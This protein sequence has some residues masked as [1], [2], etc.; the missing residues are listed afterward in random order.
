MRTRVILTTLLCACALPARGRV[1][2]E[3]KATV[4]VETKGGIPITEEIRA[5]KTLALTF[6]GR[7][8]VYEVDGKWKS[9]DFKDKVSA[10]LGSPEFTSAWASVYPD[11]PLPAVAVP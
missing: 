3:G 7:F 5:E 11:K 2:V 4:S 8:A 9:Y 1:S 6:D 10:S